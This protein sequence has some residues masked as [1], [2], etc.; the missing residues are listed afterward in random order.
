MQAFFYEINSVI[1]CKTSPFSLASRAK[2]P[3]VFSFRPS[4]KCRRREQVRENLERT[5]TNSPGRGFPRPGLFVS[6]I[7]TTEPRSFSRHHENDRK[8]TSSSTYCKSSPK[9]RPPLSRPGPSAKPRSRRRP[10][11]CGRRS[12]VRSGSGSTRTR[13]RPGSDPCP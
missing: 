8:N 3:P 11:P 6:K 2:Q 10:R 13:S 5:K 9:F 12:R 1:P 7:I 4:P